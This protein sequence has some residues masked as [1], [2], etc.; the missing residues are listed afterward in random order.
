MRTSGTPP[1]NKRSGFTLLELVVV[2]ALLGLAV[3]LVAP[4]GFRMIE[5][6]RRATEVDAALGA[7]SALGEQARLQGRA[8]RLPAG[9]VPAGAIEGLPA[10]WSVELAQEFEVQAN[11]AC[12]DA[13]G[14]LRSGNVVRPF[15]LAAPYCH[16]A[17][18]EAPAP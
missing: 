7:L 17:L 3:A 6:W 1:R 14:T 13:R 10:G 12:A 5:T 11:G 4:A 15:S 18:D 8:I 9:A 2:L 16:A